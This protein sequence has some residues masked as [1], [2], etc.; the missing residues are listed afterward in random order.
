MLSKTLDMTKLTADKIEL[1]VLQRDEAAG[2][3]TIR[4]LGAEE[5]TALIKKYEAVEKAAE[6]AKREKEKQQQSKQK[7]AA[8]AAAAAASGK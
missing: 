7:A 8:A 1:A 6:D 2:K 3:T 5:A 4:I